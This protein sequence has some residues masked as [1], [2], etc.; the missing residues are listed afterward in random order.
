MVG[1]GFNSL[2]RGKRQ[3]VG[4]EK[5]PAQCLFLHLAYLR[6][7]V[8]RFSLLPLV[9]F[10]LLPLAFSL[11]YYLWITFGVVSVSA[12]GLAPLVSFSLACWM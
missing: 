9:F 3:R 6:F 5:Q 10:S 12:F 8:V 1:G 7:S 11:V 2:I 4:C